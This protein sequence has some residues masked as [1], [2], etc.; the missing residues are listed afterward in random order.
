MIGTAM[1]E[2]LAFGRF[3]LDIARGS[4]RSGDRELPLRPES[5]A[6]LRIL[7][8]NPD[9]LV[10]TEELL[11]AGCPGAVAT[12]DTLA[13]T[14]VDL[15]RTLGD[16]G[17]RLIVTVPGSGYRFVPAAA[18]EERRKARGWRPLRWRWIY[19]ILAPLLLA[20]TV[21]VLLMLDREA[22]VPTRGDAPAVE[23]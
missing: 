6:V 22:P 5:W 3:V 19:G 9:R 11:A 23:R 18:P 13:Q 17:A 10:T 8:E 14:I 16:T 12:D 1:T 7:A 2:R 15:R 20:L 21:A 4:L